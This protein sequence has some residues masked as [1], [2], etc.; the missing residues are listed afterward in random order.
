MRT[1]IDIVTA[2]TA[3]FKNELQQAID[4]IEI[5]INNTIKDIKINNSGDSMTG[6]IVYVEKEKKSILNE[7]D[8]VLGVIGIDE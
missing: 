4:A 3:E 1:K 5:N 2:N 7:S 6:L 8:D